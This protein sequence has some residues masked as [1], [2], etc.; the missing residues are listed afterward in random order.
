M[1]YFVGTSGYSYIA[2]KGNFYPRTISSKEMLRFYA[3]Q[4]SSVENNGTF[5]KL[6]PLAAAQA[7]TNDVPKTFRFALKAPQSI[8]HYRRLNNVDEPTEDLLNFAKV[9]KKNGGPILFQLPPN[10]KKDLAR[11]DNFLT[12]IDCRAPAAFEF[13]HASWFDDETFACLR[14]HRSALCIADAAELPQVDFIVTANWSY[15]R[16]RRERYT[17]KQLRAWIDKLA[18]AKLREAYVFFKHEDTGTGPRLAR[19]FLNLINS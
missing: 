16:L 14:R 13:R 18:N 12:L 17:A 2:W 5:R 11:L 4:F 6:P 1:N 10:F 19:R 9:L 3:S 7:W 15:L 8:T